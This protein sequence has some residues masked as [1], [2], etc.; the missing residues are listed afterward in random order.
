MA[1]YNVTRKSSTDNL[2]NKEEKI[3]MKSQFA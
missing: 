2:T 1:N 3:M